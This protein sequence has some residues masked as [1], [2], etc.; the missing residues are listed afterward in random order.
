MRKWWPALC[1]GTLWIWLFW[2]MLLGQTT[3]GYR[4]AGSLYYPLLEW[5]TA[6]IQRGEW[7]AWSPFEPAGVAVVGETVSA[8]YYPGKL[9]LFLPFG[10]FLFRVNLFLS[11]HVLAAALA[12]IRCGGKLGLPGS[13][14]TLAGIAYGFSGPVLFQTTNL[15]YLVGAAWLPVA[16]GSIWTLA[17]PGRETAVNVRQNS[18]ETVIAAAAL[19]MMILGG[20]PEMAALTLLLAAA[21]WIP[22]R[23]GIRRT[24]ALAA[25]AVL[26]AAV[27]VLPA[28]NWSR[29]SE[30]MDW[31]APR[32]LFEAVIHTSREGWQSA[33]ASAAAL[34]ANPPA[35]THHEQIYQFSQAPWTM[36]ELFWPGV[37]GTPWPQNT[38]WIDELPGAERMWQPSLYQGGIVILL[39]AAAMIWLRR[40]PRVRWLTRWTLFFAIAS[41]GW[42][43]PGWLLNE[44]CRGLGAD[45][46]GSSIGAPTGGLYWGLVTFV[47]GMAGFRYPAKLWIPAALGLALLAG[48]GM[49]AIRTIPDFRKRCRQ[50]GWIFSG[51]TCLALGLQ[52]H[53]R[54]P[55]W[56]LALPGAGSLQ[57]QWFGPLRA[58]LATAVIAGAFCSAA[59]CWLLATWI[60][61]SVG[62]RFRNPLLLSLLVL[63]LA[64]HQG[65]NLPVVGADRWSP[66]PEQGTTGSDLEAILRGGF[67]VFRPGSVPE[68]PDRFL[69]QGSDTRL[70]EILEWQRQNQAPRW[71]W[72]YGL[73]TA[74]SFS[75][76]QP[77][78]RHLPAALVPPGPA[79]GR[80]VGLVDDRIRENWERLREVMGWRKEILVPRGWIA[81][82]P[83]DG[84]RPT[85]EGRGAESASR[86]AVLKAVEC[87]N[88]RLEWSVE[89]GG[90]VS[91][92]VFPEAWSGEW[93]AFVRGGESAL[94]RECGWQEEKK[95]PYLEL[96]E[97]A[98]RVVI[99]HAPWTEFPALAVSVAGGTA[100]L[101]VFFGKR[102]LHIRES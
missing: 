44:C 19:A 42:Y 27:Q 12:A 25:G 20:D 11:L 13:A 7:P 6:E 90:H 59:G 93:R 92:L 61:G 80:V 66:S 2:P 40:D 39:A 48:S 26:L 75:P 58:E 30:R 86:Q 72:R 28:W 87:S 53:N 88:R 33:G 77:A 1:V 69:E 16:V 24:S 100:A 56:V 85:G 8:L 96:P 38:R 76:I 81:T 62:D 82:L 51:S 17:R 91:R 79:S 68:P 52:L 83:T 64:V 67:R 84:S 55:V 10:S 34:I 45:R 98:Q 101:L 65:S 60:L 18:R 95:T 3:I 32:T 31:E 50:T 47:P 97:N 49:A 22:G 37:S 89:S 78:R 14:A 21:T 94:W 35:G 73:F 29:W 41:W 99:V 5:T 70:G 9:L 36:T 71:N 102:K 46:L 63:E 54:V 4:D 43:G 23:S 57:D 15:V 74:D